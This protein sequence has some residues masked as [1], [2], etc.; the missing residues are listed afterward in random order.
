M[1]AVDTGSGIRVRPGSDDDVNSPEG[2]GEARA[3]R[4]AE[5]VTI[6]VRLR[7]SNCV[8]LTGDNRNARADMRVMEF[9]P[10][11]VRLAG[12]GDELDEI[13]LTKYERAT[14]AR[15]AAILDEI[16]QTREARHPVDWFAG[17]EDA[18]DLTFGWR[19]CRDLADDGRISA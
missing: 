14:L 4:E 2:D 10:F 15:A 18:C 17:D 9:A 6:S 16:S 5:T 12:I 19:I 13:V 7:V 1:A 11:G 3:G 8:T